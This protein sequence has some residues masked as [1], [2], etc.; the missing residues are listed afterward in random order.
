M[1]RI[2]AKVPVP[3]FGDGH[4]LLLDMAGQEK[5]ETELGE[6]EF[7]HKMSLGFA[8]LS[9]SK[10]NLFLSVALRN[11]RGTLVKKVE[12]PEGVPFSEIA[13]KAADAWCL[14]CYGQK[15]DD[16]AA[17]AG[18]AAGKGESP[19]ANTTA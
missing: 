3:E 5:L 17:K 2:D 10:I 18:E 12:W 11:D 15:Y 16:W 19:L 13:A 14:A 1:T 7:M 4:F 6:W 8:V 9:V